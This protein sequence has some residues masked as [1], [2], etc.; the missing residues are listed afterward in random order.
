MVVELVNFTWEW[1]NSQLAPTSV[2]S[3]FRLVVTHSM[4]SYVI[5]YGR[6]FLS[7]AILCRVSQ[8][9]RGGCAQVVGRLLIGPTASQVS[10]R[11]VASVSRRWGRCC[12]SGAQ[13]YADRLT[14]GVRGSRARK[15]VMVGSQITLITW[16]IIHF[17][18]TRMSVASR[19][20][21]KR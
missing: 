12:G 1:P 11:S 18:F 8:V 7:H 4:T 5:R 10:R 21:C 16:P 19:L 20:R 3:L 2:T 6:K 17:L 15:S 13:V 9:T 14:N